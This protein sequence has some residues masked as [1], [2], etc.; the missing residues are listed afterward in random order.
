MDFTFSAEQDALRASVSDVLADLAAD[1][2]IRAMIDGDDDGDRRRCGTSFAALGW[3]SLLVPEAA[4]GLGLGLVDAVVVLEEMGR[5]TLPGPFLSS[6]VCATTRRPRP[7]P[8][9]SCCPTLAAG[10]TTR[11]RR[12]SR[13]WATTIPVE[14]VRTRATRRGGRWVLA[15]PQAAGVRRRHGR[16]GRRRGPHPGG[17]GVV[18]ASSGPR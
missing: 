6:S 14:R 5:V 13:S 17:H 8:R 7:G 18:P 1:G 3:P 10:T 2:R 9:P 12:R 11:H 16:L 15:R 4:G